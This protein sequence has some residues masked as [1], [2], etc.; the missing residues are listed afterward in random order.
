MEVPGEARTDAVP[1][2]PWKDEIT[3]LRRTQTQKRKKK[4]SCGEVL[5]RHPSK[6]RRFFRFLLISFGIGIRSKQLS[7]S[8]SHFLERGEGED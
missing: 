7:D 6:Y 2:T 8:R 1:M 5:I 4:L 3:C